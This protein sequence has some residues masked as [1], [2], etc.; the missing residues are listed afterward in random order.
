M[1]VL[2]LWKGSLRRCAT[3]NANDKLFQ[4]PF[5]TCAT[6]VARKRSR[7]FCQS[8]GG[9]LQLNMH[10]PYVCV[11]AWSDMVHGCMV[12]TELADTTAVSRGTSHASEYT[13]SV[14]IQKRAI[15]SGE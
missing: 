2:V 15:K 6:P 1:H 3:M 5:H 14:D 7:P 11:F 13:T 9:R 8:A 4:Y 12:Y 10:A